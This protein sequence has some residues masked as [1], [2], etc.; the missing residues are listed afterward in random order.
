MRFS[1]RD[2]ISALGFLSLAFSLLSPS[3]VSL[4]GIRPTPQM[5]SPRV[6]DSEGMGADWK[7]PSSLSLNLDGR[8]IVTIYS[9]GNV[10]L[11][12][13]IAVDEASREF[14]RKVGELAPNF[15]RTRAAST[16]QK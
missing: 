2:G 14:W 7:K 6:P 11:A 1:L 16:D 15:C 12:D 13:D 8:D 5:P 3:T 10:H 9:T 4:A